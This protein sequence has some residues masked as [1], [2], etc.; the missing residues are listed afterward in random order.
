MWNLGGVC[1]DERRR[2]KHL[3]GS[4][5]LRCETERSAEMMLRYGITIRAI[6]TMMCLVHTSTVT[7]QT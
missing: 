3:V 4:V 1:E 7:R 5:V 6:M 2:A